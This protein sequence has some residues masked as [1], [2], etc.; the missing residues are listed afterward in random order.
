MS[1]GVVTLS[2]GLSLYQAVCILR[3]AKVGWLWKCLLMPEARIEQSQVGM[4]LTSSNELELVFYGAMFASHLCLSWPVVTYVVK[5]TDIWLMQISEAADDDD[6]MRTL[7]QR[8]AHDSDD[9]AA[10]QGI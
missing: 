1:S 10:H 8:P 9:E 6:W 5:K 2:S 3:P 7:R 4:L